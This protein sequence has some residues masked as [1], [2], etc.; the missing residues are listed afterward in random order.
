MICNICNK[1]FKNNAGLSSHL[2]SCEKLNK[3]C[4]YCNK[5][6]ANATIV[7][8][9]LQEKNCKGY[10]LYIEEQLKIY[11]EDKIKIQE[12]N[13]TKI[14]EIENSFA[15]KLKQ[16]DEKIKELE[17]KVLN[18][19]KDKIELLSNQINS[20]NKI[21]TDMNKNISVLSNKVGITNNISNNQ[22]FILPVL[23][24]NIIEKS[25]DSILVNDKLNSF[26]YVCKQI[27]KDLNPYAYLTDK[28]RKTIVYN[29]GDNEEFKD[30][31]GE[32]LCEKIANNP[33][34][35]IKKNEIINYVNENLKKSTI[36][37]PNSVLEN[38]NKI[39]DV[40]N[41]MTDK[42]ALKG[43]LPRLFKH[44]NQLQNTNYVFKF[45]KLLDKL[46]EDFKQY[47]EDYLFVD[48]I[49]TIKNNVLIGENK[50]IVK[51]DEDEL[52]QLCI[53]DLYNLLNYLKENFILNMSDYMFESFKK[54]FKISNRELPIFQKFQ[55]NFKIFFELQEESEFLNKMINELS[56]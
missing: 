17:T 23:S 28:S 2:R 25:I 54:E 34:T 8:K 12:E 37:E 31:E 48:I 5:E 47:P 53:K 1:S 43:E 50:M 52:V 19:H 44:K 51:N 14:K 42:D 45:N 39:R 36:N 13:L 18:F 16:K 30:T 6:F 56:I 4:L 35:E 55:S 40:A 27:S 26:K 20:Q 15:L 32:L 33:K 21:V 11:N 3:K 49:R 41:K 38:L 7:K 29:N 10:L 24:D 22:I 9:H 46:V